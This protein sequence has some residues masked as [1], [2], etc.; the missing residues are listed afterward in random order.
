MPIRSTDMKL[1]NIIYL[2]EKS[3]TDEDVLNSEKNKA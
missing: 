1:I 2:F 3:G